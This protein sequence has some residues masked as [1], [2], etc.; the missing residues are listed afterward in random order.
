MTDNKKPSNPSDEKL[1][2][3]L[4]DN[5]EAPSPANPKPAEENKEVA[6][7]LAKINEQMEELKKMNEELKKREEA[8]KAREEKLNGPPPEEIKLVAA[9]HGAKAARMK[10]M[11][12]KQ[13]KVRIMI[14]LEGGEN[15]KDAQLPITINGYRFNVPKGKYVNVPEQVADMIAES[16]NQTEAAGRD[17]RLDQRSQATQD[18]L[19]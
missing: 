19:T 4:K 12:E 3:R 7:A 2:G 16:Y 5:G 6:E 9:T 10:E 11:L 18:A 13:P 8:L 17:F 1:L 15:P 14:P